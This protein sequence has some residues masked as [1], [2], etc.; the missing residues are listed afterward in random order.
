M[1][2]KV[3]DIRF[4]HLDHPNSSGLYFPRHT[5][6]GRSIR[7]VITTLPRGSL[8]LL[9]S[10]AQDTQMHNEHNEH[11]ASFDQ[12]YVA[13]FPCRIPYC[14]SLFPANSRCMAENTTVKRTLQCRPRPGE[15]ATAKGQDSP[16]IIWQRL[17]T[18]RERL[19]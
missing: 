17:S 15:S 5:K 2:I 14:S 7:S 9:H 6:P 16:P 8:L 11:N 4:L 19:T 1:K 3:R 10:S 12:F 13:S 18:Y